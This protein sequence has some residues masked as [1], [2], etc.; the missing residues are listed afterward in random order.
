[1]APGAGSSG[2]P[3]TGTVGL[4]NP[5]NVAVSLSTCE[6]D[7]TQ[8]IHPTSLPDGIP[9]AG[10]KWALFQQHVPTV[11]LADDGDP[12]DA[13]PPVTQHSHQSYSGIWETGNLGNAIPK[14]KLNISKIGVPHLL[15]D[16]RD[17]QEKARK[18]VETEDQA[19]V[20]N[21]TSSKGARF[22]WGAPTWTSSDIA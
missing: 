12:P 5:K 13:N 11:N 10:S 1:M 17:R 14:R 20:P 18:S 16:M 22:R 21:R 3:G 6:K 8:G 9:P 15:F 4:G 7:V 2:S 19:A